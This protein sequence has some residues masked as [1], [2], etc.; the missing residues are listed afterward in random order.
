MEEGFWPDVPGV[1]GP[2]ADAEALAPAPPAALLWPAPEPGMVRVLWGS[3]EVVELGPLPP[4][5]APLAPPLAPLLPAVPPPPP[6]TP[7]A[8]APPLLPVALSEGG[9][10][11]MEAEPELVRLLRPA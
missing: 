6:L 10:E 1:P 3:V 8:V 2:D 4:T 5:D 9:P 11:E 7:E